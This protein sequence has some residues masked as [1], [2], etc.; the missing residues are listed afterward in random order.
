[1]K[2]RYYMRGIGIGMFVTAVI[3]SI[4]GGTHKTTMSDS[5]IME[6]AAKLGM[7]REDDLLLA[8]AK[9]LAL[10]G[11]KA[12][13]NEIA[14]EAAPSEESADK[15]Q[16]DEKADKEEKEDDK[17]ADQK[18]AQKEDKSTAE[19]KKNLTEKIDTSKKDLGKT[20]SEL[21]SDAAEEAAADGTED[22]KATGSFTTITISKGS[23]STAVAKAL[24]SAGLVTDAAAYDS[25]LC[26][27][28]YDRKLV[29]GEHRIPTGSG[30]EEIAKI[31]TSPT[32]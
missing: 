28:G 10:H 19:A 7:V 9:N 2:L 12:S 6:R 5:E 16:K 29:V 14:D 3:L 17:K 26:S 31:I 18:D 23:S 21:L 11:A 27:G 4:A 32:E 15:D 20:K 22:V 1:M 24:A 13:Q 30:P 25:Y 8:D